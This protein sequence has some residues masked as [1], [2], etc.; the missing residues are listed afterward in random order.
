MNRILTRM[1]F[2][3]LLLFVM[4]GCVHE[5][6]EGSA[7]VFT[8]EWWAPLSVLLVSIAGTIAGWFLRN[9]SSRFGWGLLIVA[10]ILGIFLTPTFLL[11]RTSVDD[12]HLSMRSGIWGLTAVHDVK[13][14]DLKLVKI[15]AEK[16]TGRRGEQR[17]N[18]YLQCDRKD[19]T[20]AKVPMGNTLAEAAA[21]YFFEHLKKRGIPLVDA[22]GGA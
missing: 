5:S 7:R 13:Y 20:S 15:V 19:G 2:V 8:Y 1:G 21:P 9:T 11:D 6:T 14:D 22:T 12:T 18:Y 3:T 4:S 16:V 17:T 10:P